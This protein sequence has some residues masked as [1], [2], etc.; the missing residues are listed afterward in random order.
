M[1]IYICMYMCICIYICIHMYTFI[2]IYAYTLA[3]ALVPTHK[4]IHTHAYAHTQIETHIHTHTHTRV[5]TRTCTH[6]H[7]HTHSFSLFLFLSLSGTITSTPNHSQTEE[8]GFCF[9]GGALRWAWPWFD[10]QKCGINLSIMH[11]LVLICCI[12]VGF[13]HTLSRSRCES[14]LSLLTYVTPYT[15]ILN[16]T[17]LSSLLVFMCQFD[18][19]NWTQSLCF[20]PLFPPRQKWLKICTTKQSMV[21]ILFLE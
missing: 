12:F 2:C 8:G 13:S 15:V 19:I 21:Q 18:A 5:H 7:K 10:I 17:K 6:P 3:G 16:T 1:Y 9:G 11:W 20:P 14:T 4:L